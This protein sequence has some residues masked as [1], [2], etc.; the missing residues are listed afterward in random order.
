MSKVETERALTPRVAAWHDWNKRHRRQAWQPAE[1][2]WADGEPFHQAWMAHQ[3]ASFL[4]RLAYAQAAM[5]AAVR[6]VPRPGHLI[7][8][9]R[10]PRATIDYPTGVFAWDF[11]L[12]ETRA[13]SDPERAELLAY[14]RAWLRDRPRPELPDGLDHLGN[15]LWVSGICCHSTQDYGLPIELGLDGLREQAAQ[16]AGAHPAAADWYAALSVTLDGV[17]AYIRAHADAA[18]EAAAG[19]DAVQAAEWR[20]LAGNCRQIAGAPPA[21]FLQAA[22]LFYFLFLLNGS[23]SPGRLD[24]YLWPPLQRDLDAGRLTLDAAQEIVDCLFLK[25]DEFICYGATLGG[26]LPAGGDATNPLTWLCVRSIARLRLLSPRTALRWHADTPPDLFDA[27]IHSLATGATFPTLVNDEVMVPSMCRRGARLEDARDYT[28]C[29][30]GQTTPS[31]R[32]YGGYEDV[33]L[34]AA[35]PLTLALH[36]GTDEF[37]GARIGPATGHDYRTFAELEDAVWTQCRHLLSLGITAT[38]AWRRWGA[39]QVPDFLR[40]LL[41]HSC[42]ERGLDWRAGGADYHEG[43]VDVV[44]LTTLADALTAINRLVYGEKRLTLPELTAILDTDWAGAEDLRLACLRLPKFGNEDHEADALLRRWLRR[45]NDWLFTQ[46]TAFDGP[47]GMDIIGWS[48]AVIM[49]ETTGATPDGRRRGEA[50]ADCAGPAQGR[51]RAGITAVLNAMCSLPSAEVHGPL[52]LNLRLPTRAV[53]TPEGEAKLA[54]VLRSYLTRGGQQV[55]VTIADGETLRAAQHAPADFRDLLVRVGGFS[56]YF[57]ELESRFQDDM[58]QR[59]EH[60]V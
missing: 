38:N 45:I 46:R 17:A 10:P 6:P 29:G 35:K 8:G 22:Q 55:Q 15:A 42:V 7:L 19:A 26:Q 18:E 37:T 21:T 58:I 53:E 34:N 5:R 43:M 59:T 41:T 11:Q 51:D 50:L 60:G 32:A 27:T 52:A 56:A 48:G 47:W 28:F 54:A 25:L 20:L 40:S 1:A 4:L 12:D 33:I 9:T 13:T 49:G 57:V 36:D 23:D 14:W 16:A 2:A 30:C 31:G 24:Q 39:A 3:E 44:G